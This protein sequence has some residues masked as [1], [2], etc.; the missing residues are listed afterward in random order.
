[1]GKVLVIGLAVFAS[2]GL[3]YACF[4]SVENTA[5][6]VSTIAIPWILLIAVGLSYSYYRAIS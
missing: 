1:M 5:F 6:H 2:C 4:H 3:I